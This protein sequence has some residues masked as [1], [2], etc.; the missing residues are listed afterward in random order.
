MLGLRKIVIG[1]DVCGVEAEG[2]QDL[3][4]AGQGG[5]IAG[6]IDQA[7]DAGVADSLEEGLVTAFSGGI[8]Y[9]KIGFSG[10]GHEL[11]DQIF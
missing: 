10:F 9:H 4:I 1:L 11:L 6:D 5:R 7:L 3:R 8:H 2:A